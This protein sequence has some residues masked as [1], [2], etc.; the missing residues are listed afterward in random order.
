MRP[1]VML[2]VGT[3][4]LGGVAQAQPA[5]PA[6]KGYV[7][8]VA[9]SAFGNV[10][11]Q[12]FGAELGFTVAP[13]VQVFVEAGFVRDTAASDLGASAQIIAGFLSQTQTGVAF[14]GKQPV[15][16]GAGGIRYLIP[17]SARFEPYVL[18]GVGVAR[19]T[20]EVSFSVAGSDVTGTLPQ[21]GV[22]LGTDLSGS[23]SAAM[24]TLGVGVAWPWQRLVVDLQYRYGR[25][26]AS[27]QGLNVNRAGVGIG[28]RF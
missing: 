17:A 2:M 23:E 6:S 15:G 18:A 14:S 11:S 25:V 27:E 16:F 28:F 10:T 13:K 20:K 4:A 8:A 12:S 19:V 1:S 5:A 24:M 22:V 26:F 3:L 21:Y 9:Q 7:E